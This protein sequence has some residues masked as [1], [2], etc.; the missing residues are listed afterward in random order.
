MCNNPQ[1]KENC[2]KCLGGNFVNCIKGKCIHRSLPKSAVGAL[3]AYFWKWNG[4]YKHIDTMICCSRFMKSKMDTNPLFAG[5]TVALHNFID[6]PAKDILLEKKDYILYFGRFSE[7]KGVRTLIEVCKQLPE[8]PFVFAGTGPLVD[9]LK[10]IPNI[11]NVGFQTGD[12]LVELIAGARLTVYPSEWYENC[13]FSV[14]ESQMYGT[15]VLG[16]DIGGIPELIDIGQ[17]GEL[18]ESGNAEQLRQCIESLW[19]DKE[20]LDAYAIRC[21]NKMFVSQQQYYESLMEIYQ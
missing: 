15:P 4:V 21:R 10:D 6:R 2:E 18:F 7:E 16:A 11:K 1:T 3:E 12:A 19:Q 20:K 9:L 13:P 5:K 14:M 8:I 17:T